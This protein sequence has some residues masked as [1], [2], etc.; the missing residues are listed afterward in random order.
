[1]THIGIKRFATGDG[2]DHRRQSKKRELGVFVN[3]LKG[4]IRV[5]R[6]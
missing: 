6:H 3:E 4:V 5:E 1:V 2:Q